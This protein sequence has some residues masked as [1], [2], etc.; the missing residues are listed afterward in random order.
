M[1]LA[2]RTLAL[3]TLLAFGAAP[4]AA[5]APIKVVP[6]PM[7]AE[8]AKPVKQ[9]DRGPELD[10]TKDY[11]A[12][13]ITSK[14]EI[15]LKLYA[16]KTP[17][18]VKNFVNLAEGTGEFR[19]PKDGKVKKRAFY[20]GVYFHRVIPNF[21]IQAGDPTA[22]GAGDVGYTIP[23]EIVDGLGFDKE[24]AVGMA[25]RGKD[26]ASSQFFICESPQQ[27]LSKNY[28]VWAEIA[29]GTPGL[30]VVKK[31]TRVDRDGADKPITPVALERVEIIR[32][33][34]GTPT[35]EAVGQKAA[36]AEPA[37]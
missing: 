33:A 21:V 3:A 12:R 34:K 31:I 5:Q 37:K 25:S 15:V 7:A 22:T 24:G 26:T 30:D 19:D 32:V 29:E 11:Y 16:D 9:L 13:L 1:R 27:N 20:N 23:D 10:A 28:T 18:T 8:D 4:A 14:G 2:I 17:N 35:A 36:E 6:Q